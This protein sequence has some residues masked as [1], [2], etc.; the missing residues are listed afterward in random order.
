MFQTTRNDWENQYITQIGREPMH[1]PLGAYASHEQAKSCNRKVSPYVLSLDGSWKFLLVSNPKAAPDF[2]T[3]DFDTSTWGNITVPGSWE[4]QGHDHPIYTNVKYPFD[5]SNPNSPHLLNPGEHV[6]SNDP[7]QFDIRLNP[8][9]VPENNPTGCYIT[10]FTIPDQWEGRAVYI[11]FD[12]VESSFYIWM[13]GVQV[14]YSQDSKLSA[15]F[16]ITP[17]LTRGTNRLALQVMRWCDGSYLE[18]QDYWHL[19]GIHR[20]VTLYSKPKIH[21]KDFK[22]M[23]QFD[24]ELKDV[25]VIA[26]CYL[27]KAHGYADYSIISSLYAPN[28]E[29]VITPIIEKVHAQTSMYIKNKHNPEATSAL[30]NFTINAPLKWS[31]ESPNLYTLVF[32]LLNP[33]GE[34]VDY[35]SCKVGFRC[36][37]IGSDGVIRLNG[38]RMII[39][40]VN[41]HE[42]HPITG[43]TLTEARMR[44]EIYAIKRLNFNAVR[45]CHYPNDPLWY[46]L[47]DELGL[48][49]VDEANL[50]THGLQ[51][52]LALD[53]TWGQAFLE[54]AI[55]MVMRDKNHP[56]ILF[57][58]LGNES[59]AGPNHAAMAGWIRGYDPY[60]PVQYESWNPS[61][62]ISDLRVPMYPPLPWVDEVMA[63]TED[64]RPMVMCEY[65][66]AKSNSNGNVKKFWDYVDKYPRFQGGFV[67]DFSDK[68]FLKHTKDGT[69]Y[70]GY[71]GDF[72]ESVLDSVK[73]MCLNGVVSPDLEPHPGALELKKVQSPLQIKRVE[74]MENTY[75]LSN[76]YL[77]HDLSH[78]TGRWSLLEDGKILLEGTLEV[79][80]LAPGTKGMLQV[81]QQQAFKSG[82]EYFMNFYFNLKETTCW[83][84]VGHELYS[85]QFLLKSV[86]AIPMGDKTA[87]PL[88]LIDTQET[89]EILGD[90]FKVIID[91]Q[92]GLITDYAYKEIQLIESGATENYYRAPTGIDAACGG[93]N[94]HAKDWQE[95]GLNNLNREI[96]NVVAYQI[97]SE[98]VTVEIDVVL[99]PPNRAE[100][101]HSQVRYVIYGDGSIQIE[102]RVIAKIASPT[103]PRI[104]LTWTLSKNL[105]QLKWYGRGPHENYMDRKESALVGIYESTVD[106]QHH[107]YILPVECGGKEDVRWFEL[108]NPEGIGLRYEGTAPLH[109]DVH[110]NSVAQYDQAQHTFDLVPDEVI[111][112]NTDHIHSGL[113]GDTGWYKNIHEEYQVKPGVYDYSLWLRPIDS[114]K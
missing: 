15:E 72:G 87:S 14:G 31:S 10:E 47:C 77:E 89:F 57:W 25:E 11:N 5:M 2:Y 54:R 101:I 59:C 74:G 16:N 91:Q 90:T 48:Y 35:E 114:I 28:G 21:I 39:R 93:D 112:L 63:D 13:N 1:V 109:F 36:I 6:L 67:W 52:L 111:W 30:F 8:P 84:E 49:L 33:E 7:R 37:K 26:Y 97:K 70:F 113:G 60:R 45:T 85:E 88:R 86:S 44:E 56:S 81:P 62:L 64:I 75:M 19:S 20:S 95:A 102:N 79:P 71:G 78:L 100:G 66:Y 99:L 80:N 76:T 94:C 12:S 98:V 68:A 110:R 17:Y 50:E 106:A 41:R 46:D 105:G 18:D 3:Q 96:L 24:S 51:G 107:P 92:K 53:P 34:A 38:K 108:T 82:S 42:H 9:F 23:Q 104:G 61:T 58:S 55:R 32:T 103:L 43:R 83:A 4:L 65:A 40:G 69:P 22:I 29:E 27:H 73:D